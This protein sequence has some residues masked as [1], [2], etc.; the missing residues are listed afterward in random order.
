MGRE[1][2]TFNLAGG[3]ELTTMGAAWFVSYCYYIHVNKNHLNWNAVS[4]Y[5]NRISVFNNS[6][7]YHK[8]WLKE[9]L[10]MNT[11][12]LNKNSLGLNGND[13][14]KMSEELLKII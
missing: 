2:H 12:K 11:N 6:T 7:P 5:K 13:I 9:V 14:K 3:D 1:G 4:T 10:N 8:Y